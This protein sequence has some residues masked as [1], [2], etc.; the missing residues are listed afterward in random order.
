[1]GYP[2]GRFGLANSTFPKGVTAMP[3]HRSKKSHFL[4]M[5]EAG[6][7]PA[8]AARKAKIRHRQTAHRYRQV[9]LLCKELDRQEAARQA[10]KEAVE[11]RKAAQKAQAAAAK[12]KEAQA[13]E[14]EARRAQELR[15]KVC[16]S[17][18]PPHGV[19]CH[20]YRPAPVPQA[21]P[22]PPPLRPLSAQQEYRQRVALAEETSIG[23]PFSSPP[24][25]P[26]PRLCRPGVA[27]MAGPAHRRREAAGQARADRRAKG[28]GPPE[29]AVNAARKGPPA[30]T[31]EQTACSF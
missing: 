21:P 28:T 8:A 11:A 23:D 18:Q 22:P 24:D 16:G 2:A 27:A 19:G 6:M 30:M 10:Q 7:D 29:L 5:L 14:Q 17:P 20:C 25:R 13:A 12:A 1:M 9:W 26:G 4:Q 3:P 31:P 15:C